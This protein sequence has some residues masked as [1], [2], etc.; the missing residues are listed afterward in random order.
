MDE[1]APVVVFASIVISPI[2]TSSIKR[3]LLDQDYPFE[4]I[5][6]WTYH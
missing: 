6:F 2:L 4:T 1:R 3:N 5:S